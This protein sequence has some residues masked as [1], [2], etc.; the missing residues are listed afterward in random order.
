[1]STLFMKTKL[2]Q[3]NFCGMPREARA[4]DREAP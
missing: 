1:M 2:Q 4:I 3:D